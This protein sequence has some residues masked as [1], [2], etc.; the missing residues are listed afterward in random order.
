MGSP[1]I[2][3]GY[4]RDDAMGTARAIYD[5]LKAHYGAEQIFFDTESIQPGQVFPER[6]R[7][8]IATA[9]VQLILV[10]PRWATITGEDGGQRLAEPG[11]HVR[12]EV[13][14]VLGSDT[15][16]LPVL[17]DGGAMPSAQTLPPSIRSLTDIDGHEVR[18]AAI[19][20]DVAELIEAIGGRPR[21]RVVL[22]RYPLSAALVVVALVLALGYMLRPG[23]G[24]DGPLD[25]DFALAVAD[26]AVTGADGAAAAVGLADEA[27]RDV[28]EVVHEFEERGELTR[29]VVGSPDQIGVVEGGTIEERA[30]AAE[31]LAAEKNADVVLYGTLAAT[32]GAAT[33]TAEFY[34]SDRN[35]RNAEELA[36]FYPLFEL[37][38]A[39]DSPISIQRGVTDALDLRAKA[40]AHLVIGLSYYATFGYEQAEGHFEAALTAW[41]SGPRPDV[42]NTDGKHVIL[43]LL[44][45]VAGLQSSQ[46]SR[47]DLLGQAR[48]FYQRAIDRE[49]DYARSRFGLAE[50]QFLE[51]GG[52]ACQ[53]STGDPD[54]G[55]LTSSVEAFTAVL[56]LKA[57]PKSFL[58]LRTRLEIGRVYLCLSLAGTDHLE[59]AMDQLVRVA[60]A[61]EGG[62]QRVRELSAE[63]NQAIARIEIERGRYDASL[64]R[65]LAAADLTQNP[66]RKAFYHLSRTWILECVQGELGRADTEF[67]L[68]TAVSADAVRFECGDESSAD[69]VG[70]TEGAG[71]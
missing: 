42:L 10:G 22:R 63:A 69:D 9:D 61:F 50:V 12:R 66:A 44:G 49:P 20:D 51:A 60:G 24:D 67:A 19:D 6:T 37:D 54:I 3:I 15:L 68:A 5:R 45:N 16:V 2:F 28:L 47:P 34:L 57:P 38:F 64:E 43:H 65:Y 70:S 26:F 25:G 18:A 17:I 46:L 14:L 56:D 35:L 13:E 32:D 41:E 71:E 33:F 4:R 29:L 59:K 40:L 27:H 39:T 55:L 30:A 52:S 7:E 62:E 36:G 11:D 48:A 21:L 53:T 23:T 31:A 58:H 1:K 8:A